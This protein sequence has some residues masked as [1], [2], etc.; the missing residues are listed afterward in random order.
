MCAAIAVPTG[1][2]HLENITKI[3]DCSKIELLLV[4]EYT[5]PPPVEQSVQCNSGVK[6]S[7]DFWSR[8]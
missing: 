6:I 5:I 3:L 2:R 1:T 7:K 8:V 4:L